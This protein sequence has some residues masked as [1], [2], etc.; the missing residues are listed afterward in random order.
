MSD[1]D[2]SEVGEIEACIVPNTR[3]AIANI[4]SLQADVLL[5][6]Y[7]PRPQNASQ[8]RST[9]ING[10]DIHAADNVKESHPVS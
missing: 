6:V 8:Y 7:L 9:E 4:Q 3:F 2:G 5:G 1:F 10:K